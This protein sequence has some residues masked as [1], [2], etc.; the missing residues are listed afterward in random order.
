M[1]FHRG[2]SEAVRVVVKAIRPGKGAEF[3]INVQFAE[4]FWIA[5]NDTEIVGAVILEN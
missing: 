1:L 4:L 3:I 2:H 5:E